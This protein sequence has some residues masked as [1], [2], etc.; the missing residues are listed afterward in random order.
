MP[1]LVLTETGSS[2]SSVSV[3]LYRAHVR[4]SKT[5][6]C[7]K[8]E[9]VNTLKNSKG[10][11]KRLIDSLL[12]GA[13][14]LGIEKSPGMILAEIQARQKDIK[15]VT[16]GRRFWASGQNRTRAQRLKGR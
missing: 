12:G 8:M 6:E 10:F 14:T 11:K 3:A 5:A 15:K 1:G 4:T 7:G 9:N 2:P 16:E 13:S